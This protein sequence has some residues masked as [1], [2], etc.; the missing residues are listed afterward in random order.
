MSGG[1]TPVNPSSL[2]SQSSRDNDRTPLSLHQVI[3]NLIQ[4][5]RQQRRELRQEVS[6]DLLWRA[7]HHSTHTP[8]PVVSVT[9]AEGS[10][11]EPQSTF[12]DTVKSSSP[13]VTQTGS[14]S[15]LNT[16]S[17][18]RAAI[19][20]STNQP[21]PHSASTAA[22]TPIRRTDARQLSGC[23]LSTLLRRS[24]NIAAEVR[25][26]AEIETTTMS[27]TTQNTSTLL[28]L[29]TVACTSTS[30]SS[31]EPQ[32]SGSMPTGRD[33]TSEQGE[34]RT[35]IQTTVDEL[36]ELVRCFEALNFEGQG[37]FFDHIITTIPPVTRAHSNAVGRR[38]PAAG[39]TMMQAGKEAQQDTRRNQDVVVDAAAAEGP[40]W[41]PVL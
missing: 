35:S 6:L 4:S 22:T 15:A 3:D 9:V 20:G 12:A 23:I 33:P 2:P 11:V 29:I 24:G 14:S 40:V 34:H 25:F 5:A 8:V 30:S 10:L 1:R 39:T 17:Q 26:P 31:M 38:R 7:I 19:S 41:Q 37:H 21:Q 18:G 32:T 13:S 36:G 16:M 28:P 27:G